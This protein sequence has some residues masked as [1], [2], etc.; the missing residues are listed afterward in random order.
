MPVYH[1]YPEDLTGTKPDNL[2]VGELYSLSDRQ[3][4]VSVP[5]YGPFFVESLQ[6]YDNVTQRR[7]DKGVDYRVPM[8]VRE[9]SLRTG[10]EIGDSILIENSEVSSQIRLTYQCLGGDYQNNID[11]IV[12]IYESY[13][14]D[15]RSVDWLTGIYGKPTEFPP[16]PHPHWLSEIYGF[17]PLTVQMERIVQAI[18]LGNTPAFEQLLA[19]M[20]S[21]GASIPEMN[22]GLPIKKFVSLEGLLHVLDKY[23]FNSMSMKPASL[24]ISNGQGIWVDVKASYVPEDVNYYWSIEHDTSSPEDFV[25]NTGYVNLSHGEGRFMIQTMK[26]LVAEEAETFRIALRRNSGQGQIVMLSRQLTLAKHRDAADSSAFKAL[27]V[28]CIGD[29]R[30]ARTKKTMQIMRSRQDAS[31]S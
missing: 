1:R 4:R 2:I 26:D 10:K 19:S 14:N 9:A 22:A 17:E 21:K 5:K 3:V 6:V 23:N 15:N 20:N 31:Y 12:Q 18:L 25:A 7:L 8:I 11:N 29:P 24:K 28:C 27:T 30:I 16:S 13:L